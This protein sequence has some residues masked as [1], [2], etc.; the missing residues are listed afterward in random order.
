MEYKPILIKGAMRSPLRVISNIVYSYRSGPKAPMPF[1]LKFENTNLCNLRC[2]MCP[3]SEAIGLDRKKGYVTF[4]NF[5]Y[6][7]DQ[8]KPLYLNLTGI[9][10]PFINP[11]IYKIVKYATDHKAVVKFDTNATLL[12]DE[13]IKKIFSTNI[14]VISV[15]FDGASKETYE[16]IRVRARFELVTK[17]FKRLV[18]LRNELKAKTK[19]HMFFV[20]QKDNLHELPQFIKLAQD[21]GVDYLAGNFVIPL[22]FNMNYERNLSDIDPEELKKILQETKELCSKATMTLGIKNLLEFLEKPTDKKKIYHS[23][24]PCYLPWYAPLV[25]WDGFMGPCDFYCDKEYVFGNVFEEPFMKVWNSEAAQEFRKQLVKKRIGICKT[26][27][28]DES[29]IQKEFALFYKLPLIN[30]LTHRPPAI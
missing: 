5:K 25:T 24:S 19:I 23:D 14:D 8:V 18:E 1:K 20:L 30:R 28:V 4:E 22:G 16:K 21:V 27:G 17:N 10:E 29:Y 26:C 2:T 3:H 7:F 15:S 12:T 11:D 13:N 9:G 6:V